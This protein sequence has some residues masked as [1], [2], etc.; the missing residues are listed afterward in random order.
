MKSLKLDTYLQLT[1]LKKLSAEGNHGN[2]YLLMD[3]TLFKN[4]NEYRVSTPQCTFVKIQGGTQKKS[5]V[6]IPPSVIMLEQKTRQRYGTP[7]MQTTPTCPH[8]LVL[9][10]GKDYCLCQKMSLLSAVPSWL[11][12]CPTWQL[13]GPVSLLYLVMS[14]IST[15][16]A[17]M[18]LL[19]G[20][21]CYLQH[22]M[23]FL[24]A[25]LLHHK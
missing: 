21:L 12:V 16:Q 5:Y 13:F 6:E 11:R 18:Q 25:F 17:K 10:T 19:D 8:Y 24:L 3:V 9:Q 22:T 7:S 20:A 15:S 14:R 2:D 23:T 1:K 4:N